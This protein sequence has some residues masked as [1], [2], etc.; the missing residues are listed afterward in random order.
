LIRNRDLSGRPGISRAHGYVRG[1]WHGWWFWKKHNL[2]GTSRVRWRKIGRLRRRLVLSVGNG[3]GE[4]CDTP[5]QDYPC[6]YLSH[7]TPRR[8]LC[9]HDKFSKIAAL[10]CL[11]YAHRSSAP[12]PVNPA[13]T[14]ASS[15]RLP[16][17]S[18]PSSIAVPIASGI[19]PAVVFP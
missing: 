8:S 18:F 4:K 16:F 2:R 6:P 3:R 19:V 11:Q 17:L 12:P 13:P 1:Q 5:E 10:G 9:C 7:I 15:P 14:E